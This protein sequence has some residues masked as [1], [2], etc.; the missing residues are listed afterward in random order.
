[1]DKRV[2][3]L[4]L[5]LVVSALSAEAQMRYPKSHS[6]TSSI[7][8]FYYRYDY[9]QSRNYHKEH[10]LNHISLNDEQ[11]L[12]SDE[13]GEFLYLGGY[14]LLKSNG[15]PFPS[16]EGISRMP[17]RDP[18]TGDIVYEY[19]LCPWKRGSRHGSGFIRLA[20]GSYHKVIWRWNRVKS[21][22]EEPVE[23]ADIERLE[24]WIHDLDNYIQLMSK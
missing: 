7:N 23:E 16:G 20:D 8:A 13:M 6:V 2:I 1:M 12:L 17:I 5:T 24:R 10:K 15:A 3:L 22:S 11:A 19:C 9:D 18:E 14:Q 21:I 4:A